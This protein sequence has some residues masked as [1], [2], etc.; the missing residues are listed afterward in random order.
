MNKKK[1][2]FDIKILVISILI[3]VILVLLGIM[4]DYNIY[5]GNLDWLS[6]DNIFWALAITLATSVALIFLEKQLFKDDVDYAPKDIVTDISHIIDENNQKIISYLN[7]YSPLRS[8]QSSDTPIDDFN[9]IINKE[10]LE[11]QTYRYMGDRC[12]YLSYRLDKLKDDTSEHRRNRGLDVEIF[13]PNIETEHFISAQFDSLKRKPLYVGKEETEALRRKMVTDYRISIIKALCIF[14]HLT[15]YYQFNIYFYDDLPFL[16]YELLDSVM[17]L[18]LLTMDVNKKYPP[19]FIYSRDSAFYN[20]FSQYHY[21][22]IKFNRIKKLQHFDNSSLN[23]NNIERYA[24]KAN[25][26]ED[27]I[28][29]V[30]K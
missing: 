19:T 9:S 26:P 7:L 25:L 6:F 16:R 2:H 8:Y 20:A 1:F 14:S 4:A 22:M 11:S 21:N 10:F 17:V 24:R 3:V 15:S 27:I 29:E 5:N 30:I 12:E 28:N 18:S 13:L 23:L